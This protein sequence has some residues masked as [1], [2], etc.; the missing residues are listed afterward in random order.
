MRSGRLVV[1]P[2]VPQAWAEGRARRAVGRVEGIMAADSE[3]GDREVGGE[4]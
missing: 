2:R 4:E 3:R 1:W